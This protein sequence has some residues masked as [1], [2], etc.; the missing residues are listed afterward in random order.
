MIEKFE[1][2]IIKDGEMKKFVE[3]KEKELPKELKWIF[4]VKKIEEK[5]FI[6]K[7]IYDGK[8]YDVPKG[9]LDSEAQSF[10][11]KI[12]D[13]IKILKYVNGKGFVQVTEFEGR[14]RLDPEPE[15]AIKIWNL[16]GI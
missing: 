4:Q 12:P 7:Y 6:V 13:R 15:V 10:I 9:E 3:I 16:F 8:E 2:N 14:S 5:G 11:P 1:K